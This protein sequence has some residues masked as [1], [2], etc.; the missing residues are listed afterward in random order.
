MKDCGTRYNQNW[1]YLVE[2]RIGSSWYYARAEYM[3]NITWDS[4]YVLAEQQYGGAQTAQQLF[5]AL[6][7]IM[8][9]TSQHITPTQWEGC[10][11]VDPET[12]RNLPE[13][14][15][16]DLYTLVK[17]QRPAICDK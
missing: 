16:M 4:K 8:P 10:F 7:N 15:W 11:S 6:P 17:G 12:L 14:P 13:L 9:R 5:E 1:G 2:L 3:D